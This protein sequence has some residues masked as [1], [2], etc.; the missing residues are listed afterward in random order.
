[1]VVRVPCHATE[2]RVVYN[3][4]GTVLYKRTRN[5]ANPAGG[6]HNDIKFEYDASQRLTRQYEY[7]TNRSPLVR[8]DKKTAYDHAGR[9]VCQWMVGSSGACDGTSA[10]RI[11]NTYDKADRLTHEIQDGRDVAYGYDA[12]GNRTGLA[13]P[14]GKAAAYSYDARGHLTGVSFESVSLAAYSYDIQG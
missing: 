12:A 6:D 2:E 9:V 8:N 3:P 13:W 11:E 14:D 1:M 4:N 7:W 10:A 5:V